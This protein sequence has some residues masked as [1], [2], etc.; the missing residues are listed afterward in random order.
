MDG[1]TL[2]IGVGA[3]RVETLYPT[4]A[5]EGMLGLV[6]V[7]GIACQML[8]PLVGDKGME[9]IHGE[10]HGADVSGMLG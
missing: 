9:C 8:L 10:R 1:Y 4:L 3:R 2:P 7:E 6:G 5:A